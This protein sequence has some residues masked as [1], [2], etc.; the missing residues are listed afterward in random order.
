MI[1]CGFLPSP[2]LYPPSQNCCFLLWVVSST[3]EPC[4]TTTP[5]LQPLFCGPS[6]LK[7]QSF[8]QFCNLLNPTTPLL[9]PHFHGQKVATVTLVA[10]AL[11]HEE[12][13]RFYWQVVL[14]LHTQ[15]K[16][17][18]CY[19]SSTNLMF[20]TSLQLGESNLVNVCLAVFSLW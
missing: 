14:L 5:L 1:A 10:K 20:S 4:L 17:S 7:V 19:M 2:S 15:R 8:S 11:P 12:A 9:Q 18:K 6:E 13:S 3:V 16:S